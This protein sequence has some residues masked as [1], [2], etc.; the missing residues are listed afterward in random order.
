MDINNKQFF[1]EKDKK[2]NKFSQIKELFQNNYE[3]KPFYRLEDGIKE[4]QTIKFQHC[5]VILS[6]RYFQDYIE[7]MKE[8]G[9]NLKCVP[10]VFVFTSDN[11]SKALNERKLSENEKFTR[12]ETLKYVDDYFYNRGGVFS[13]IKNLSNRLTQLEKEYNIDINK[14]N[15]YNINK[16][17]ISENEIPNKDLEQKIF[18]FKIDKPESLIIPSLYTNFISYEM[19][20]KEK[21]KKFFDFLIKKKYSEFE[22]DFKINNLINPLIKLLDIQNFPEEIIIRYL[23]FIYTLESNFYKEMNEYL[24][25]N[26]NQGD[27]EAFISLMYRGL[28]LDVFKKKENYKELT[29][30]KAQLMDKEE[31]N[32]IKNLYEKKLKNNNLPEK[33][34]LPSQILCSN[35]FLSFTYNK[36]VYHHFLSKN[37]KLL[38]VLFVIEKGED[39]D[40][41]CQAFIEELSRFKKEC[42]I[43]FFPFSSFSVEHIDE[44]YKDYLIKT[45]KK[46]DK[47]NKEIKVYVKEEIEIIKIK[48]SYLGKYKETIKKAIETIN[49]D[50]F[51]VNINNDEFYNKTKKFNTNETIIGNNNLTIEYNLKETIKTTIETEKSLIINEEYKNKY[52]KD[53]LSNIIIIKSEKIVEKNDDNYYAYSDK[54]NNNFCLIIQN[55]D[56]IDKKENNN[57]LINDEFSNSM[58]NY[59]YE[60]KDG[61]IILCCFDNQIKII[62]KNNAYKKLYFE[63][64]LKDHK[65]LITNIIELNNE[66]L[67]SCSFDGTIKLWKKNDSD[68]YSKETNLITNTNFIFYSIIEVSKN[69]IVSL[70]KNYKNNKKYVLIYSIENKNENLKN[71][72]EIELYNKNLINLNNETFA[73][74]GFYKIFVLNL[75]GDIIKK[76]DVN[77]SVICLYKLNDN[78]YFISNNEGKLFLGKDFNSD[79]SF[80]QINYSEKENMINKIFSIEQ[81]KDNTI[82]SRSK[83]KIYIWKMK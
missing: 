17:K 75:K 62:S 64:R 21:I 57:H 53:I 24:K 50:N 61:R 4:L 37:E 69:V 81:F 47:N 48:L 10:N 63:Q 40:F 59:I 77:Y 7:I 55:K 74:G 29:L 42:E 9:K 31:F 35:G 22:T 3:I 1:S 56:L 73:F 65:N 51:M 27:Y 30:Y 38:T 20:S 76:L 80:I 5:N 13:G 28:Y 45:V 71:I 8:E 2:N 72:D 26:E 18:A 6:G 11:F 83:E 66:K 41:T 54:K 14:S 44:K 49:V 82:I 68:H 34:K 58:I 16:D 52:K 36:D 32:K 46:K 33:D 79:D 67:C 15:I 25:K 43:L 23:T 78:S 12:K 39:I 70:L 19:K 60:L